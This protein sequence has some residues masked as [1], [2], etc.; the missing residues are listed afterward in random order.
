M[1]KKQKRR[2]ISLNREVFHSFKSFCAKRGVAMSSYVEAL[3]LDEVTKQ[4]SI[5]PVAGRT[6]CAVDI[7]R[8]TDQGIGVETSE[9]SVDF[10]RQTCSCPACKEWRRQ[11]SPAIQVEDGPPL[12]RFLGG[13][14][15]RI[16]SKGRRHL[17]KD[18]WCIREFNEEAARLAK[19]T[20]PGHHRLR[21]MGQRKH[22][23]EGCWCVKE[24][25][26]REAA[27]LDKPPPRLEVLQQ[28]ILDHI[29]RYPR[30][31]AVIFDAVMNDYGT[32]TERTL[33]RHLTLLVKD[34]RVIKHPKTMVDGDASEYLGHTYS[35]PKGAK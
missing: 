19:A 25:E 22:L 15:T 6:V 5:I 12:A 35:K 18:C 27:K 21:G 8:T 26:R 24:H 2:T 7:R 33:W 11:A 32:I 28:T 4:N 14:K 1:A 30:P 17:A 23:K 29:T 34:G 31:A 20:D 13:H 3:I 16:A 9:R 10:V